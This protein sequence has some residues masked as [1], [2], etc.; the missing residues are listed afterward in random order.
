MNLLFGLATSADSQTA[1]LVVPLPGVSQLMHVEV[2]FAFV[3]SENVV[4]TVE[5]NVEPP[6]AGDVAVGGTMI[7][8][9]GLPLYV[10]VNDP[11]LAGMT[12]T[13]VAKTERAIANLL[14]EIDIV[15]LLLISDP[16]VNVRLFFVSMHSNTSSSFSRSYLLVSATTARSVPAA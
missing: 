10:P 15:L 16:V 7:D 8:F 6:E 11:A 12:Q 14:L 3:P 2:A 5:E 4:S 9:G 1:S 13:A